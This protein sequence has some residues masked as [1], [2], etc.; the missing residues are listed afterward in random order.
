MKGLY[1]T[2]IMNLLEIPHFGRGKDA[3]AYMKQLLALVHGG[4]LWM[5]KLILIDVDLII[6]ITGFPIV[7]ENPEK[8]LYDKTK[9]KSLEEEIKNTYNTDRGSRGL[10]FN[11]ISE[12]VMRLETNMMDC[13]LIKKCCKEESPARVIVAAT[14]CAKT[15]LL[16]WTRYLLNLFLGDCKD[17]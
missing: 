10:T 5:E 13:K 6:E 11:R 16:S 15:T 2:H 8:Y 14:Q 3:N 17:A 1:N 4:V 7:G 12:P 9:E